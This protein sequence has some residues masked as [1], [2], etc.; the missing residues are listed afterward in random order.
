MKTAVVNVDSCSGSEILRRAVWQPCDLAHWPG[1]E[2]HHSLAQKGFV[3]DVTA[4]VL[5]WLS[6]LDRWIELTLSIEG[7]LE[8]PYLEVQVISR[9]KA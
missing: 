7:E 3:V 8:G 2:C 9:W 5:F 1:R 4:I 6:F